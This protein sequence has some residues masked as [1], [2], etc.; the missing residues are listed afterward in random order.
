MKKI[1]AILACKLARVFGKMIGRGSSM[2]GKV[3]LKIDSNVLSKIKLP[4]YVIAVTGSNGKTSTVEMIHHVLTQGGF[5][6]AYN[7]EGSNQIDGA[8]TLILTNSTLF[9]RFKKQVLLLEVDERYAKHIFKH[10]VPT[11]YVITNI[12]RDQ[13]TRNGHPDFVLNDIKKSIRKESI[14]ILDADDPKI[15]A[16]SKEFDNKC[17]FYGISDHPSVKEECDSIYDDGYYCPVCRSRL[18]YDY[19]QF[20]HIG[21]YHCTK[22]DF[23]RPKAKIEATSIDQEN[24]VI[25]VNN[26]Y[27]ISMALNSLHNAYNTLA[28]FTIA[29]LLEVD[30]NLI[31]KSLS[32]YLIKNGR[33]KTFKTGQKEGT[34][35]ISKH[36]NSISYNQNLR[37]VTE[38]KGDA[39]VLII[40]DAIS[41]KYFTSETSWLWDINFEFLQ[42]DNVKQVIVSGEYSQDLAMRMEYAGLKNKTLVKKNIKTAAM[43]LRF[44]AQGHIF[45]L[46]CFS[47]EFKF[48]KEVNHD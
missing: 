13:L 24:G 45:V 20:A 31:A 3:A 34:L 27:N 8:A 32:D 29:H 30:P 14:L 36:E 12:Y 47:D 25:K 22:C 7:F 9:G 2:P 33:V 10:F 28:T 26:R 18:I 38:Y 16:L 35:L 21:K 1:L 17:Y 46:T 11:H 15:S 5:D 42:S 37:Y 40:V 44:K 48:M 23:I 6:V 43:Y 41:R 19:R 4:E 39:T